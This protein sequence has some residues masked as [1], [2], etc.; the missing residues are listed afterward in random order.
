MK[1]FVFAALAM[2][3]LGVSAREAAADGLPSPFLQ[4]SRSGNRG[5][6]FRKH[7]VP[8]F[9]AAPWYSYWPYDQHFMT[10]SPLQG[11]YYAPPYAGGG[12]VNPYFPTPQPPAMAVPVPAT[13]V[14]KVEKK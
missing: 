9:Q 8:A 11:A 6:F 2:C 13:T 4:N 12:M 3:V 7:P 10:P 5:L 1:K 14:P